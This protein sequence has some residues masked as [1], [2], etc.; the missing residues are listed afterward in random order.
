MLA[1]LG[2]A[3]VL[4]G[5]IV[6]TVF[7]FSFTIE[8]ASLLTLILGASLAALGLIMRRRYAPRIPPGEPRFQLLRR[9][10]GRDRDRDE[11]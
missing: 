7:L 8:Q 10:L 5:V 4:L 2:T 9:L 1:R 11:G 6:L 3:F